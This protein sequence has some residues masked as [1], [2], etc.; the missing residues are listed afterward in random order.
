MLCVSG[1]ISVSGSESQT[2]EV[3]SGEDVTLLC[4][5]FSSAFTQI[6]W[7]RV[8]SRSQPHCVS[9]MFKPFEPAT[10]CEGF[11]TG[12][13]DV[14]S[15]I[16]TLFLKIKQVNSSD[17]GLYFCGYYISKNPIIM[18]STYLQV[19]GKTVEKFGLSFA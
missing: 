18:D 19:Q 14:R 11:Q 12:K 10:Y 1:W 15:N 3:Q 7:F 4:S 5:N 2:V 9:S 6:I 17:S 13:F 16:S 8:V